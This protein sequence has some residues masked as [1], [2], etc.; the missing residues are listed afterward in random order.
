MIYLTGIHRLKSK[1]PGGSRPGGD[2][3]AQIKDPRRVKTRRAEVKICRV[4]ALTSGYDEVEPDT[5]LDDGVDRILFSNDPRHISKPGWVWRP[6]PNVSLNSKRQTMFVKSNLPKLCPGYDVYVWT[7]A[8]ITFTKPIPDLV[9]LYLR[10]GIDLVTFK[11]PRNESLKDEMMEIARERV[12][13]VSKLISYYRGLSQ[14]ERQWPISSENN[15]YLARCTER[16]VEMSSKW[17]WRIEQAPPRD[18]LTFDLACADAD[19]VYKWFD[20]GATNAGTSDFT[21]WRRHNPSKGASRRVQDSLMTFARDVREVEE[22]SLEGIDSDPETFMREISVVVPVHNASEKLGELLHSIQETKFKGQVILVENGSKDDALAVC[23][24]F[25]SGRQEYPTTVFVSDVALGFAGACNAGARIADGKYIL[26]LN[27]DTRLMGYWWRNVARGFGLSSVAAVGAVGNVAGDCSV[28]R[29]MTSRLLKKGA[30][31]SEIGQ[32]CAAFTSSWSLNVPFQLT[33]SASGH[34]FV[35]KKEAFEEVGGFDEEAFPLGYGEEVDLFLRLRRAGWL[36]GV[37]LSW[38]VFHSGQATFGKEK[39][40]KLVDRGR[41]MLAR[42][43][44]E[45]KIARLSNDLRNNPFVQTLDY[46]LDRYLELVP[47]VGVPNER[48]VND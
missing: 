17:N 35:V 23:R 39:R 48:T 15:V 28:G 16:F 45:D 2:T 20:S 26:F 11:H 19:L 3:S 27:S 12:L 42:Q 18:Q 41:R 34:A 40:R 1:T 38:Y 47:S 33:R 8:R 44:G 6:L 30:S 31:A 32:V 46:D 4:T 36:V 43:Y 22:I 14:T 29:G 21:S 24:Q 13:P 9:E 7:D 37:E 10:D 25:E 5:H